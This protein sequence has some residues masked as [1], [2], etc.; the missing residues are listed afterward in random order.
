MECYYYDPNGPSNISYGQQRN[1]G[2]YGGQI[3][4]YDPSKHPFNVEGQGSSYDPLK[5]PCSAQGQISSYDPSKH[6][7]SA[8]SQRSSYDPSKRPCSAQSQ[9]SSYDPSQYPCSAQG[10]RS[11]YRA[12]PSC[13]FQGLG[14]SYP[15]NGSSFCDGVRQEVSTYA[16]QC[17]Q[18][19]SDGS[20]YSID[21]SMANLPGSLQNG[22]LYNSDG[23]L[24][25]GY[26]SVHRMEGSF[27]NMQ[28]PL[29]WNADRGM[30]SNGSL[31]NIRNMNGFR[32]N[33]SSCA[34]QDRQMASQLQPNMMTSHYFN[35]NTNS[36]QYSAIASLSSHSNPLPRGLPYP[37]SSSMDPRHPMQQHFVPC[38]MSNDVWNAHSGIGEIMEATS[39]GNLPKHKS[40]AGNSVIYFIRSDFDPFQHIILINCTQSE[41]LYRVGAIVISSTVH[42]SFLQL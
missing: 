21:R 1:A 35:P 22:G 15:G 8:Q 25:S 32:G 11:S 30:N 16:A 7:C 26:G 5:T 34:Q 3:S 38:A 9:R 27:Q 37:G 17:Q 39:D 4:S 23:S 42:T 41:E 13:S 36:S 18:P 12:K 40:T 33:Y 28:D 29:Y 10:Q 2:Y 14:M 31:R 20:L 24:Y 19:L 6:P